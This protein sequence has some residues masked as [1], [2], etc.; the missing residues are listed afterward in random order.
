MFCG[1]NEELPP[2]NNPANLFTSII[3]PRYNMVPGVIE[4]QKQSIN[5][6]DVYF[7]FINK[8]E[9]TLQSKIN[10]HGT[11]AIQWV[12]NAEDRGNINT[13]RTDVIDINDIVFARQFDFSSSRLTIDHGDSIIIRYRWDLRTD[14]STFLM[15]QFKYNLD[16]DCYVFINTYRDRG[17]RQ[18]SA[19]QQFSIS[20]KISLFEN[21]AAIIVPESIFT[22]CFQSLNYGNVDQCQLINPDEPCN[23]IGQ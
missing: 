2:Q 13:F 15:Q 21:G 19:K 4:I 20:A 11:V 12:T 10:I 16:R 23:I 9:E 14:D 22:I 3:R 18:I 8:Y 5:Y 17:F 1:C 7:V 6:L